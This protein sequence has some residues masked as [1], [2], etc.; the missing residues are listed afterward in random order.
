M[1]NKL[2]RIPDRSPAPG[3]TTSMLLL[4]RVDLYQGVSQIVACTIGL[5]PRFYQH[6]DR[7]LADGHAFTD[8]QARFCTKGIHHDQRQNSAVR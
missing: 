2:T 3:T 1:P 5:K 8:R 7:K 6:Q 4:R